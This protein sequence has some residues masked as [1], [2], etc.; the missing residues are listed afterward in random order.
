MVHAVYQG[1][2]GSPATR[3]YT[4]TAHAVYRACIHGA[5][6][7]SRV[8]WLTAARAYTVTAHAVYRACI[9]G[10]RCLSRVHRLTGDSCKDSDCRSCVPGVYTWSRLPIKGVLTHRRLVTAHAARVYRACIHGARCLSR[11]Y[12]LTGDS[13]I[14]S[15]CTRCLPGVFIVHAVY[16]GCTGLPAT[17]DCTRCLSCVYTMCTLSINGVNSLRK[18]NPEG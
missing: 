17:H 4:V 13:C 3:A 8:Y 5:G 1:C 7:L 11:V 18:A 10:A 2:T 6:C 12:W 16:Q 15:D 9:H 14:H